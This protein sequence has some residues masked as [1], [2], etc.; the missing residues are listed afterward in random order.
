MKK[1]RIGKILLIV[2]LL[3]VVVLVGAYALMNRNLGRLAETTINNADLTKLSDGEYIGTYKVLPVNVELK[4]RIKNHAIEGIELLRH[5]NG[6]G[7]LAEKIV[8]D[9][10][11]QQRIDVD[12]IAGAT[13]SS[14][15]ILKAIESAL[16]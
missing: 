8:D 13:Y 3:F 2:L 11:A 16:K 5:D 14:K 10:I 1:L 4:V 9:V 7:K 15:V 12:S 6:Q